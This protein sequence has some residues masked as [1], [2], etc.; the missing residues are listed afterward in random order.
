MPSGAQ[1]ASGAALGNGAIAAIVVSTI[2]LLAAVGVSGWYLYLRMVKGR[3]P[4]VSAT[5][6]SP[7]VAALRFTGSGQEPPGG[8]EDCIVEQEAPLENSGLGDRLKFPVSLIRSGA[9]SISGVDSKTL[10][11]GLLQV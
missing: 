8:S 2:L 3:L 6:L 5:Y 9:S 7:E 4:S 10:M 11:S 1:P